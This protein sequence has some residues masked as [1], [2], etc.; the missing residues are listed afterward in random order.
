MACQWTGEILSAAKSVSRSGEGWK[1][2]GGWGQAGQGDGRRVMQMK[3]RERRSDALKKGRGAALCLSYRASLSPP[4][5][6]LSQ[7]PRR[8]LS[9]GR[10]CHDNSNV[11]SM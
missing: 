6:D 3:E 2:R 11:V 8:P 5:I 7:G 1:R 10:L 4:L 9:A